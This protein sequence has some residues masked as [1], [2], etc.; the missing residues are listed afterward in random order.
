M[1]KVNGGSSLHLT[2]V[3]YFWCR[4]EGTNGDVDKAFKREL[5]AHLKADT[6]SS[7]LTENSAASRKASSAEKQKEM[8]KE[9][10]LIISASNDAVGE[11]IASVLDGL[12]ASTEIMRESIGIVSRS[13]DKN[14]KTNTKIA[15]LK[16]RL[17]VA[18]AGNKHD[19]ALKIL[20][21][22]NALVESMDDTA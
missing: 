2:A 22:M 19:D 5:D 1:K 9:H 8:I 12:K 7:S 20:E 18:N 10:A 6:E 14:T 15:S 4:C 3:Y 21:E 16:M 13:V 11:K 17:N